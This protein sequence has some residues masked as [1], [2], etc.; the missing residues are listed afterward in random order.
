[1]VI[2]CEVPIKKTI[3]VMG[4]SLPVRMYIPE[5]STLSDEEVSAVGAFASWE[6]DPNS[7][8]AEGIRS[9]LLM[10]DTPVSRDGVVFP[11]VQIGGIGYIDF[12]TDGGAIATADVRSQFKQ[13][14]T[15]NFLDRFRNG[16]RGMITTK[17]KDDAF[18]DVVDEYRPTGAYTRSERDNKVQGT[19]GIRQIPGFQDTQL[20]TPILDAW[21]EY[22][23]IDDSFFGFV[24]Y[25]VPSSSRLQVSFGDEVKSKHGAERMNT[26]IRNAITHSKELGGALRKLH[27]IGVVHYQPHVGNW[28]L[29]NGVPC[30]Y[31]WGTAEL[32]SDSITTRHLQRTCDLETLATLFDSF[33]GSIFPE[34]VLDPSQL[35][36]FATAGRNML[37]ECYLGGG[38]VNIFDQVEQGEE[39]VLLRDLVLRT[40]RHHFQ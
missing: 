8:R 21:G 27:D 17:V 9:R 23:T 40:I 1:M 29:N 24:A 38:E 37:L 16:R 36:R 32:L 18:V 3:E 34:L 7:L 35:S 19:Y 22:L 39:E 13:P 26:F 28:S 12:S 6:R 33:A 30:L 25:S 5:G 4:G 20:V 2:V 31:D 15:A 11:Y 14:T 10:R